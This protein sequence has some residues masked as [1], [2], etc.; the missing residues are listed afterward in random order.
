[1]RNLSQAR[2]WCIAQR[3]ALTLFMTLAFGLAACSS[4]GGA[5]VDPTDTVH[6]AIAIG[7]TQT[8]RTH[9]PGEG[10][11]IN[12]GLWSSGLNGSFACGPNATH[13]TMGKGEYIG[14]L[15]FDWKDGY[16]FPT[17]TTVGV[18]VSGLRFATCA[19]V[20]T[21]IRNTDHGAY[22]FYICGDGQQLIHRYDADTGDSK[23]IGGLDQPHAPSGD[24]FTITASSIGDQQCMQVT[25][26]P[27]FCVTDTTYGT[28]NAVS[29]AVFSAES[30][31]SADFS[32]F[33]FTPLP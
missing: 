25:G 8:Y 18:T 1:M 28:T 29:I 4:P 7:Q 10:C 2:R 3:G 21:R 33:V 15:F 5:I 23:T 30:G 17:N 19:G 27:K 31:G 12:G 16:T 9:L 22:G 26:Q 6:T 32:D 11:D 20:Q 24:T 14:E 13:V